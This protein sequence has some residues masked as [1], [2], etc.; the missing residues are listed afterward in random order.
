MFKLTGTIFKDVRTGELY[1]ER[2][3]LEWDKETMYEREIGRPSCSANFYMRVSDGMLVCLSDSEQPRACEKLHREVP[4]K[5]EVERFI[6]F[7]NQKQREGGWKNA[8]L[9]ESGREYFQKKNM[10]NYY[11]ER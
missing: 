8:D 2:E 4:T 10:S 11:L 7:F 6:E 5:E 1:V 9:R 3:R